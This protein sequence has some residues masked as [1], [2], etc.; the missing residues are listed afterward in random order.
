MQSVTG[1]ISIG[2]G[3]SQQQA[4]SCSN[5]APGG[6]P[7][8]S[9][10]LDGQGYVN[11]PQWYQVALQNT[12]TDDPGSAKYPFVGWQTGDGGDASLSSDSWLG[13]GSAGNASTGSYGSWGA[14]VTNW[15]GNGNWQAALAC[16]NFGGSQLA[17]TSSVRPGGEAGGAP[18]RIADKKIDTIDKVRGRAFLAREYALKKNVTRTDT[19]TCPA[20]MVRRGAL[21]YT[22]QEFPADHKSP[23][24]KDRSLVKVKLTN[25]GANAGSV[26][27]TLTRARN[28]T[29]VQ[30]QMRCGRR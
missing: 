30:F 1:W 15:G 22:V 19:R 3:A 13:L 23:R 25:R 4:I 20:G 6:S 14:G 10:S 7:G 17:Q 11:N 5:N 8:L 18:V 2:G 12:S 29:V 9:W 21:A 26:K 16:I 28:P 24:W 27:M